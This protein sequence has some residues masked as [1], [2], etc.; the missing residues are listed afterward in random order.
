MES[1]VRD[2]L[3]MESPL[4]AWLELQCQMIVGAEAALAVLGVKP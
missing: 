2:W 1:P 4:R 3:Q